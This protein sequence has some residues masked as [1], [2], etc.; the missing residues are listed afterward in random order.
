MVEVRQ[1]QEHH[2]CKN[3]NCNAQVML[4]D[5]PTGGGDGSGNN[6][7]GTTQTASTQTASTQNG[8]TQTTTTQNG[9]ARTFFSFV[10][11]IIV[12]L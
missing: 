5:G 2:Y 10:L 11:L 7:D 12:V 9:T 1:Y 4:G 8:T 6:S 3:D